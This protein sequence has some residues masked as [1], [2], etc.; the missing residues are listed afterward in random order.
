M[1][2]RTPEPIDPGM[3]RR[4]RP[5]AERGDVAVVDPPKH[6]HD[7]QPSGRILRS[8]VSRSPCSDWDDHLWDDVVVIQT[9]GC[10]AIREAT[11]GIQ[12]R[13]RRGDDY[14]RAA[15]NE[16]L[17]TPL[18]PSG[19]YANPKWRLTNAGSS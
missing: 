3:F 9:C 4:R 2:P 18:P 17:G 11:I 13:R 5:G 12:N 7:W 19:T 8:R 15:G 10:G 14:R 1:T 6:T 16:P